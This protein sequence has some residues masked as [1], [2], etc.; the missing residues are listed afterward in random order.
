MAIKNNSHDH[1]QEYKIFLSKGSFL[2][3]L[4]LS[5]VNIPHEIEYNT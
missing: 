2:F 3:E 4:D 1:H 5:A